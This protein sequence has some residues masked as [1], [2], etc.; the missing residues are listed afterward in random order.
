M[1]NQ[2]RGAPPHPLPSRPGRCRHPPKAWSGSLWKGL[3][4]PR[5]TRSL[6]EGWA[7]LSGGSSSGAGDARPRAAQPSTVPR[8]LLNLSIPRLHMQYPRS[9]PS[10]T[11]GSLKLIFT[12]QP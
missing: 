5:Q 6:S 3:N 7:R 10:S 2:G 4:G 8:L 12:R 11:Y 9:D 1:Q